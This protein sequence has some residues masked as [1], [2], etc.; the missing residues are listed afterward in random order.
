[1]RMSDGADPP[2]QI[3]AAENILISMAET[4]I[5]ARNWLAG[6]G[7]EYTTWLLGNSNNDKCRIVRIQGYSPIIREIAQ[8]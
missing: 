2:T 1:M 4:V 8:I 3:E 7:N 6:R 5:A